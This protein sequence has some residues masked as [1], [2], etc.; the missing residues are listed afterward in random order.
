MMRRVV[1]VEAWPQAIEIGEA[2]YKAYV[3]FVAAECIRHGSY[4]NFYST[5]T[6][7]SGLSASW[8]FRLPQRLRREGE[9]ILEHVLAEDGP[10]GDAGL[11]WPADSTSLRSKARVAFTNR[12]Q[13]RRRVF[14]EEPP[15]ALTDVVDHLVVHL[16]FVTYA[17]AVL[18]A[19]PE[20][21]PTDE[22]VQDRFVSELKEEIK[23]MFQSKDGT[24]NDVLRDWAYRGSRDLALNMARQADKA[25]RQ[26]EE[27]RDGEQGMRRPIFLDR[28][29]PPIEPSSSSLHA[30][31]ELFLKL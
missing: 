31:P 10:E 24:T 28:R 12:P 23:V 8:A 7:R 3:F 19:S 17:A 26:R 25:R 11:W 15:R 18:E 20:S 2:S 27:T 21:R 22:E 9:S 6:H 5:Q 4:M 13:P 16:L 14:G 29:G 30:L 1:D